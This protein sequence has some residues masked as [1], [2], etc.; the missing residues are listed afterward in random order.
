MWLFLWVLFVLCSAGF[1]LWS[2]HTTFEQ[3]KAWKVYADKMGLTFFGGNF[4]SSP[5]MSGQVKGRL[6]NFYPQL[7][8]NSRNQRSTQTVVEVFFKKAPDIS[9]LVAS[10]G[11]SDLIESINYPETLNINDPEW[12]QSAIS[13]CLDVGKTAQWFQSNRMYIDTIKQL[14]KLPFSSAFLSDPEQAFLAVRTANPLNDPRK[15][16]QLVNKLILL[17]EGLEKE[18]NHPTIA[19][20]KDDKKTVDPE[21]SA[22]KE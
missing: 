7:V 1:F 13:R 5:E 12:P 11:F 14:F 21:M 16:N 20:P 17:A 3:K 19:N 4:L 8:E 9:C 10:P 6:V 2:Y 22:P 18:S 15:I